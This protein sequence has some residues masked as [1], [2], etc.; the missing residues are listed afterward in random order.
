MGFDDAADLNFGTGGFN[1]GYGYNYG[2]L[3]SGANY[4][5]IALDSSVKS[6]GA[7]SLR[8]TVPSNSGG[9]ASGAFFLNFTNPASGYQ[10]GPGQD[11]YIQW[12]NRFSQDQ[13]NTIYWGELSGQSTLTLGATSGTGVSATL[14][15]SNSPNFS[16]ALGRHIYMNL[17]S[18]PAG[19]TGAAVVTSVIDSTHAIVDIT[20]TFNKLSYPIGEWTNDWGQSSWKIVDIS[21]GDLPSCTPGSPSSAT[22]PTTCWDF[23]TVVT[24]NAGGARGFPTVYA[25]CGGPNAY[26]G[27]TGTNA[28]SGVTYQNVLD[29]PYP[30]PSVPPCFPLVAD[31]WITFQAHIHVGTWG[32]ASSTFRLWGARQGQP[33]VLI[34]ECSPTIAAPHKCGSPYTNGV[35][36]F[37]SNPTYKIGKLW[38][39]PYQTG[40]SSKQTHPVG[41]V[42]YD[43]IIIST[44]QIADPSG[45]TSGSPSA[46]A[47]PSALTVK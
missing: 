47:A 40:K 18:V 16:N 10:V 37:N 25:N 24:N 9:A 42:W 7:S 3:P 39:L 28:P 11:V 32:T 43:E 21:A 14:S 45:S 17:G 26:Q 15:N 19:S 38:L 35:N 22:C 46:P 12:R 33:S 29:C 2:Y 31:E 44:Q 36:Y 8:F 30:K 20:T 23:E 6:D 5:N 41:Y 4:S 1:G 27:L 13:I 34:I